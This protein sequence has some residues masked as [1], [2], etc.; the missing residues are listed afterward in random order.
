M[1]AIYLRFRQF[2]NFTIIN[3]SFFLFFISTY[4]P[5]NNG[6]GNISTAYDMALLTRYAMKNEIYKQI[7][8]TKSYQL[9]TNYKMKSMVSRTDIKRLPDAD[10]YFEV[11][12]KMLLNFWDKEPHIMLN[13]YTV[14]PQ[15]DS[16]E[17][18]EDLIIAGRI[19]HKD[20]RF[21]RGV[22]IPYDKDADDYL[23]LD[24]SNTDGIVK[25]SATNYLINLD[26]YFDGLRLD[27][28][29]AEYMEAK[30]NLESSSVST[31]IVAV[32][33][34]LYAFDLYKYGF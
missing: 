14:F 7:V 30:T 28:M 32:S 10:N 21:Y 17:I 2:Y 31:S 22:T 23:R 27:E 5:Y 1:P 18:G 33:F 9:K 29:Q 11:S 25:R 19:V 16:M 4:I 12:L 8:S 13:E 15:V 3:K 6:I 24:Y 34:L 26:N 20:G